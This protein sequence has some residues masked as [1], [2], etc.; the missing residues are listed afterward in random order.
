MFSKNVKFRRFA[1][2]A[3]AGTLAALLAATTASAMAQT[4]PPADSEQKDTIDIELNKLE[5][6]ANGCRAFMVMHNGTARTFS[7]LQLDLVVFDPKGIIVDQLAVDMA[8]LAAGKTMVK[9]FEIAGHDCGNFGR[10]LLNDVLTCKAGDT[11]IERCVD[12]LVPSSRAAIAF[13]K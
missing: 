3:A 8:P 13:I 7:N 10:V 1:R 12:L 5:P 2:V 4:K 9:V 6:G 11:A